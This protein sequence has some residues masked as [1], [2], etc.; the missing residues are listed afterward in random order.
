MVVVVPAVVG[1]V[2]LTVVE[3]VVDLT[4]DEVEDV[5]DDDVDDG[6]VVEDDDVVEVSSPVHTSV[7]VVAPGS[8]TVTH[9][10]VVVC[11]PRPA[12]PPGRST[13]R[14]AAT[15]TAPTE[16]AERR[17]AGASFAL[18]Y[19]MYFPPLRTRHRRAVFRLRHGV[20]LL[21]TDGL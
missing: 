5:D 17:E 4:V 8:V 6:D 21:E 3:V 19:T 12:P 16:S 1:V 11:A 14:A 2:E 18:P 9:V 7:E 10:V 15:R 20:L 13:A